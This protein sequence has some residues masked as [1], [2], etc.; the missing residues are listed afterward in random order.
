M[1]VY[2][3][4]SLFVGAVVWVG[5]VLFLWHYAKGFRKNLDELRACRREYLHPDTTRPEGPADARRAAI[6]EAVAFIVTLL[7]ALVA[8]VVTLTGLAWLLSR[9]IGGLRAWMR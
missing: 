5:A 2:F 1:S 9:A 3:S 7:L 6:G 8:L 4:P